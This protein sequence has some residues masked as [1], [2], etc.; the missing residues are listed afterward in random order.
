METLMIEKPA[1][2]VLKTSEFV[3]LSAEMAL[4]NRE[5]TVKIVLKIYKAV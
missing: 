4:Q 5:K 1:K 3:L 2:L